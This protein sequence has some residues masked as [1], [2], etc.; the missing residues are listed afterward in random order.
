MAKS[1]TQVV[2]LVE[3]HLVF[4][5]FV[6]GSVVFVCQRRWSMSIDIRF[7]AFATI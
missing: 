4:V 2:K 5:L 7:V 1:M 3:V 6:R